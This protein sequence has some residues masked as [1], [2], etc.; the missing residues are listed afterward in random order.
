M[1]ITDRIIDAEMHY[2]TS[3]LRINIIRYTQMFHSLHEVAM[4][5]RTFGRFLGYTKRRW[6]KCIGCTSSNEMTKWSGDLKGSG[7]GLIKE[8]GSHST[9]Q[10]LEKQ[11]IPQRF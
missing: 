10:N 6:F 3:Q 8:Q 9:G 5:I 1:E 4:S 11:E 7:A 2:T